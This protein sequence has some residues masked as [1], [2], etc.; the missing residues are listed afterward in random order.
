MLHLARK[1]SSQRSIGCRRE[2]ARLLAIDEAVVAELAAHPASNYGLLRIPKTDG[3]FREIRPPSRQLR[4]VQ[5]RM[6][7]ELYKR[8][9]IPAWL[10]GGVSQRSIFTHASVHVGKD[11]VATLDIAD[12]FPGTPERHVAGVLGGAG[13]AD[14]AL[15]DMLA[16]CMLDGGLPQGSPVS[17]LLANLA[18]CG[19]DH[20]IRKLCRRRGLAYSRYVD[21]I[22][23]SGSADFTEL[24]GP[25]I[26]CIR[27][28]GYLVATKKVHFLPRSMRQT[29]TGLVVN[30]RLRPTK[31]FISELKRTIHLCSEHGVV[32]A[33]DIEGV[34][35]YQLKARLNGRIQHIQRCDSAI[36]ERLRR[37]MFGVD[38]SQSVHKVEA[39]ESL[40]G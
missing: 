2:L 37:I 38:W 17:S 34:Q 9:K 13:F 8:L 22:A 32:L 15:S 33:A 5:R 16:L 10:H 12:F 29:V 3:R 4:F 21:D 18:F 6:L 31:E 28:G 35:P 26:E 27:Q 30:D 20:R 7:D 14:S 39:G 19:V 40:H 36:G 25:F 23:V 11:M 1:R 24:R